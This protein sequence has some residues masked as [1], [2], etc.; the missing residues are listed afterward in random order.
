ME[1]EDEDISSKKGKQEEKG[2]SKNKESHHGD[3][4]II[5]VLF[6]LFL[7]FSSLSVYY[8]CFYRNNPRPGP[9]P[10]NPIS[11]E[12]ALDYLKNDIKPHYDEGFNVRDY[13]IHEVVETNDASRTIDVGDPSDI[14]TASVTQ[15]ED[16][17]A[18]RYTFDVRG[19]ETY[20][21]INGAGM[22]SRFRWTATVWWI[23]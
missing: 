1:V 7:L 4:W 3:K 15:I 23:R 20:R 16:G 17:V 6:L 14:S 19:G 22:F 12:E 5:A 18:T 8:L 13:S 11:L 10:G 2:D 21:Y 9:V